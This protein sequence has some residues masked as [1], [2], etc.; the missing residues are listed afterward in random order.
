MATKVFCV[1]RNYFVI[2]NIAPL[3][4]RALP[5]RVTVHQQVYKTNLSKFASF[6]L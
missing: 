1:Y 5:K 4:K 6:G 3:Q 2:I